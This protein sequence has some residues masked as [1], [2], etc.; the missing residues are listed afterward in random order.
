MTYLTPMYKTEISI[1]HVFTELYYPV[2]SILYYSLKMATYLEAETCCCSIAA[3][4]GT[5]ICYFT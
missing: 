1:H 5:D 3:L 2:Y 4:T